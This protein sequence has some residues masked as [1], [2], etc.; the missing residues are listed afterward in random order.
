M[1]INKLKPFVTSF[2]EVINKQFENGQEVCVGGEIKS[3]LVMQDFL[4]YQPDDTE[5]D[6]DDAGDLGVYI[7]LDDDVGINNIILTTN[8]YQKF[9]AQHNL[10]VGMV[11]LAVGRVMKMKFFKPDPNRRGIQIP[12]DH[13][14]Q[15]TRIA[16][17]HIELIPE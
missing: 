5:V 12:F 1:I 17:Y 10:E 14:E 15:T 13:E 16:A 6:L 11:V 3:I 4:S 9:K 7:T 8:A 2:S